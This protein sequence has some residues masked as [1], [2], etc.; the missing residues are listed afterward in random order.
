[1][2]GGVLQ[3]ALDEAGINVRGSENSAL[4][5]DEQLRRLHLAGLW[6]TP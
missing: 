3:D 2:T 1:M 6:Q 4:P 5:F